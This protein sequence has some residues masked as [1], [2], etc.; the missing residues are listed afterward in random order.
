MEDCQ[1][2]NLIQ[3]LSS[4]KT[5]VNIW[6]RAKNRSLKKDLLEAKSWL[7]ELYDLVVARK[8]P[9]HLCVESIELEE[10]R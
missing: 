9:Q 5:K 2:L 10:K 8:L 1:S 6:E 3:K 4:L 7:V